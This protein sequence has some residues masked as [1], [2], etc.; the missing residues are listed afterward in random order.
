MLIQIDGNGHT[1]GGDRFTLKSIEG[2]E[3]QERRSLK[4]PDGHYRVHIEWALD[5][6]RVYVFRVVQEPEKFIRRHDAFFARTA[7]KTGNRLLRQ[8]AKRDQ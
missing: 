4:T 3:W 6:Y 1:T 7:I 2:A 8:Y 5:R